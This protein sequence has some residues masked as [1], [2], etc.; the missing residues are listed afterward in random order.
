MQALTEIQAQELAK[1]GNTRYERKLWMRDLVM[2]VA[3]PPVERRSELPAK[4]GAPML[5][6][7]FPCSHSAKPMSTVAPGPGP[8]VSC[9]VPAPLFNPGVDRLQVAP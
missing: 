9:P 6:H 1:A 8:D 7:D 5:N 4:G 3:H 2:G